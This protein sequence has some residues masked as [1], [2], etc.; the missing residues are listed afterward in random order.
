MAQ[1]LIRNLSDEVKEG[2][3]ERARAN[4]RSMEA[5]AR[6]ILVDAVTSPNVTIEYDGA[7]SG[8]EMMERLGMRFLPKRPGS[9]P[10]TFEETQ[11]LIDEFV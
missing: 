10:V 8:H 3:R 4:G 6:A 1:L 2:L 9:R 7:L 5:E 11:D